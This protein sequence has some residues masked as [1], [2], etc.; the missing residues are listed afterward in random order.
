MFYPLLTMTYTYVLFSMTYRQETWSSIW[1][2][3]YP[4]TLYRGN[5]CIKSLISLKNNNWP[6]VFLGRYIFV[7]SKCDIGNCNVGISCWIVCNISFALLKIV[8]SLL[9]GF[10]RIGCFRA[11]DIFVIILR[12][13]HL[14][15]CCWSRCNKCINKGLVGI[16]SI[17]GNCIN[18]LRKIVHTDY[19]RG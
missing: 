19:L 9:S 18:G 11:A 10:N 1:N 8:K 12:F 3:F 5:V 13:N 16:C 15:R 4:V 14:W 7:I 17:N 2:L 6:Q